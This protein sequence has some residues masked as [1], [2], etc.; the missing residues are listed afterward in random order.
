MAPLIARIDGIAYWHL[1]RRLNATLKWDAARKCNY[2][3]LHHEAQPVH[4]FERLSAVPWT[5]P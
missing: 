3:E 5:E 2:L 4:I 1:A